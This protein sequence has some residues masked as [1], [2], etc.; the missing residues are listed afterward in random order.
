MLKVVSLLLFTTC[1]CDP[2]AI[3]LQD[4]QTAA[5]VA[6]HRESKSAEPFLDQIASLFGGGQQ[7][8]KQVLKKQG[9]PG[10]V[11]RGPPPPGRGPHSAPS[12]LHFSKVQP[13][14]NFNAP[15]RQAPPIERDGAHHGAHGAHHGHHGQHGQQSSGSNLAP[16]SVQAP[17]PSGDPWK[18]GQP[19]NMAQIQDLQVQ[20]E[21]DLM[22]VRIIFDRPFYG[23]VFSKGF[24]R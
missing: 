21:K 23:M 9:R 12:N 4:S 8:K 24:Y 15:K 13:P 2:D 3:S 16:T 10:P 1:L 11:F 19:A 6:E 18:I 17:R 5:L 20:C 14:T 22:R 7:E